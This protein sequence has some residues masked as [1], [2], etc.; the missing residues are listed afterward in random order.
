MSKNCLILA[1]SSGGLHNFRKALIIELSKK[2]SVTAS[3]PL[4]DNVPD[5]EALGCRMIE[6][7]FNRRSTNPV[8]DLALLRT[9][10]R[11][12]KH[13]RPDLVLTY[14]IK[15]NIYG[16]LASRLN[17]VPYAANITGLGTAFGNRGL[18]RIM[19]TSMYRAALKKAKVVFFE[20]AANRDLFVNGK[21]IRASQACLLN[22]AGVN[23][24]RFSL[25]P[26]PENER[27]RFLFIGRVMREKGIEELI[28]AARRLWAEGAGCVL[29]VVGGYEE[30]YS[31]AMERAEAEGWLTYHGQQPDVRPFI[32]ACDCFV[33][34][35][36]H[37]G[38]ANTNLECAA[39]GRPL[40]TSDIPGCREAVIDGVSGLLCE[41]K[42]AESLYKAMKRM[43][44]LPPARRR[45]MGLAGRAHMEK[46]FDKQKVVEKT[47][48]RL[49][50][51]ATV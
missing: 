32:A 43:L 44:A 26:Y 20:N 34:P 25:Q 28:A 47:I 48:E 13:E 21:I 5:L 39:S 40:I 36:W 51:G 4:N 1:N 50:I 12:I 9:Y 37:E 2:M 30:D 41:P 38:M 19:V 23:L 10:I 6:T 15:P 27:F 18:L 7:E 8:K 11:L 46:V 14:T 35:S 3:V 22:G 49:S 24:E 42:N 16:G 45:A 31:A 33:L 29:D 17:R